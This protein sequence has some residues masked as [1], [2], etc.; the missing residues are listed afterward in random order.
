MHQPSRRKARQAHRQAKEEEELE[1]ENCGSEITLNI[2]G[3]S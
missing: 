1:A 2:V 3:G